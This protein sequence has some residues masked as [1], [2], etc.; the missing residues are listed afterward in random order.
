MDKSITDATEEIKED[1]GVVNDTQ[2]KLVTFQDF[3]KIA[4]ENSINPSTL[5]DLTQINE[6]RIENKRR[7]EISAN[8]H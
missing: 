2:S 5:N 4:E 8:E 3:R 7:K 1:I 6:G